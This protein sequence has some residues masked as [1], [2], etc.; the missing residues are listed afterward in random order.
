M[1]NSP[2]LAPQ[3]PVG[4]STL[5]D[6]SPFAPKPSVVE[7]LRYVEVTA[8]VAGGFVVDW[9]LDGPTRQQK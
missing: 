3:R 6:R 7:A 5:P 8:R 4:T 2:L 9:E 1:A